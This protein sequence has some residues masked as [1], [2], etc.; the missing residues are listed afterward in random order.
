MAETKVVAVRMPVDLVDRLDAATGSGKRNGF[1][2]AAVEAALGGQKISTAVSKPVKGSGDKRAAKSEPVAEGASAKR[3]S[4][5]SG[6]SDDLSAVL[7]SLGGRRLSYAE[8]TR[9]LG[10]MPRRVDVAVQKLEAAGLVEISGGL[11]G[12]ASG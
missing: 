2:V 10:W 8:I 7:G 3:S 12:A 6:L 4:T 1:V 5:S 9:V 11:I